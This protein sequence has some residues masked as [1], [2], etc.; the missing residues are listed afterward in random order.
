MTSDD[1]HVRADIEGA[2]NRLRT[3]RDEARVKIHLGSMDAR[4]AWERLQPQLVEAERAAAHASKAA[5]DAIE[6][7]ARELSILVGAL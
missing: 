6:D 5:L 7:A 3:L 1:D 4:A 2:M